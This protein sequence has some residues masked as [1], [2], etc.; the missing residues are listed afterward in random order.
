MPRP[1]P[2]P[3]SA[4]AGSDLWIGA[5]YEGG[6]ALVEEPLDRMLH[7]GN[8]GGFR[9][10][11]SIQRDEVRLVALYTT[12]EDEDWPDRIERR[13]ARFTYYGDNKSPGREL[14]RTPK[15]G[16]ELLRRV[17]D[18]THLEDVSRSRVPPFFV[19]SSASPGRSVRFHGL[20]APGAP[21]LPETEDLV[22][23]WKTKDSRRFQNYRAVFTLLD[24][25][26]VPR[27][28]I[29]ELLAGSALGPACPGPWRR[30]VERGEYMPLPEEAESWRE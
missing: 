15:H 22:A 17:Y 18:A 14:H 21:D 4:L 3:R 27:A 23:I 30:W 8:M 2:V 19:F 12:F 16:N 1:D 13:T 20:A 5:R 24:V 26:P 6:S 28:W 11:G 25:D 7:C 10:R 29:D 9:I